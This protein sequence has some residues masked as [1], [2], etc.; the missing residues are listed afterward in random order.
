MKEAARGSAAAA[1]LLSKDTLI[2]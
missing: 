1:L 2:G